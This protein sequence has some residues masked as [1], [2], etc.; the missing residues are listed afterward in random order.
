MAVVATVIALFGPPAQAAA[1]G[2]PCRTPC[3]SVN[4]PREAPEKPAEAEAKPA[5]AARPNA[6]PRPQATAS[7][8]PAP[9]PYEAQRE[10]VAKRPAPSRRCTDINMR[11]AVGEPLSD[12]D[13]K[14]LRSQC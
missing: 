4:V 8:A 3:L 9:H 5:T 13:M 1:D 11:A 14:T 10:P 12:E 7:A 2:K 6:R